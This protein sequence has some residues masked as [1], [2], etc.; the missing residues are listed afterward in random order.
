MTCMSQKRVKSWSFLIAYTKTDI[1]G[2]SPENVHQC[3][4]VNNLQENLSA[5]PASLFYNTFAQACE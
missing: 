1:S 5:V 3:Y 2:F 4:L